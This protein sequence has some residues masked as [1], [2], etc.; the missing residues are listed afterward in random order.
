ALRFEQ[1][2]GDAEAE[3]HA[4]AAEVAHQVERRHRRLAF[5]S[6]SVQHAG[7]G[8]V[9]DVVA[10]ARRKRPALA[11]AGHA[12]VNQARVFFKTFMW[13]QTQALHDA[14]PESFDQSVGAPDQLKSSFLS[15][16]RLQFQHYPTLA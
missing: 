11:P 10:G 7:E 13:T 1:R 3:Q 5:A 14:R 12:A 15:G 6:E 4:A 9:I 2:A 16:I 8:D